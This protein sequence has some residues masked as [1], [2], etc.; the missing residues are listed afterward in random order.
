MVDND[1]QKSNDFSSKMKQQQSPR[2]SPRGSLFSFKEIA[3]SWFRA[4]AGSRHLR[5]LVLS[6]V[7]FS[8]FLT[9]L[10]PKAIRTINRSP[11]PAA[12]A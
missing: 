8:W 7:I 2:G 6:S 5:N 10:A 4:S 9:V 12:A 3:S 1:A 11:P